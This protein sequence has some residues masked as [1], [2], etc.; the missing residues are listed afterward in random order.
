MSAEPYRVFVA[1]PVETVP[2]PGDCVASDP[3]PG[4]TTPQPGHG[5]DPEPEP[6]TPEEEETLKNLA[7]TGDALTAPI[8]LL[9]VVACLTGAALLAQKQ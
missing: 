6:T 2:Q 1:T 8:A 9:G 5:E 4:P 3:D 7:N